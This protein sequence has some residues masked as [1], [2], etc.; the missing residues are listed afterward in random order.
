MDAAGERRAA[1]HRRDLQ[2]AQ[3]LLRREPAALEE[4]G[5]RLA[6]LPAMLRHQG[7]RLGVA[8]SEHELEELAQDTV[9]AMWS[10]LATYEGRATLETWA[11]RF[12]TLE[13]LKA[14]QRRARR[15]RLVA[16]PAESL[17]LAA[18]PAAEPTPDEPRFESAEV[19]G[20]LERLPAD[21]ARVIRSRHYD[22]KSF[23]EIAAAE[24]LPLN[25][26]K[27]R[28]YRGLA[29]LRE[30]LERRLSREEGP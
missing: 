9:V 17:E 29:R 28:Y 15:P 12:A 26:V 13:L 11:F 20:E 19:R 6:C 5:R 14:I 22:Q 18:E 27:A 30:H 25:T 2:F 1:A 7:K 23:D 8:L 4:M 10:K 21:T 16:D 24:D 3:R